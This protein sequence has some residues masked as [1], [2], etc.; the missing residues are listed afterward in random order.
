MAPVRARSSRENGAI[1]PRE[2]RDPAR[3][4]GRSRCDRRSAEAVALRSPAAVL[5]RADEFADHAEHGVGWLHE[6]HSRPIQHYFLI[7]VADAAVDDAAFDDHRLIA[8]A[9]PQIVERIEMEGK[10]QFRPA[11]PDG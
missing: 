11:L 7:D 3:N 5:D 6:L 9:E 10:R 8:E 2:T 4:A 1:D